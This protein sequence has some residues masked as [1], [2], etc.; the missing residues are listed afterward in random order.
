MLL[1]VHLAVTIPPGRKLPS[2]WEQGKSACSFESEVENMNVS[3]QA[4][5]S[6]R[7]GVVYCIDGHDMYI[8]STARQHYHCT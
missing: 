3:G 2:R 1:A 8:C 5:K 6:G 7:V 4:D